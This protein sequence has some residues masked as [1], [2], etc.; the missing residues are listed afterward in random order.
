MELVPNSQSRTHLIPRFAQPITFYTNAWAPLL[1][2]KDSHNCERKPATN[3]QRRGTMPTQVRFT[4]I[5]EITK[6]VS[7]ASQGPA[8]VAIEASPAI[9]RSAAVLESV[10]NRSF[11]LKRSTSSPEPVKWIQLAGQANTNTSVQV[12]EDICCRPIGEL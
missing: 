6:Q 2:G 8:K 1:T 10:E 12:E 9:R 11:D 4:V 5:S 7:M 3:S